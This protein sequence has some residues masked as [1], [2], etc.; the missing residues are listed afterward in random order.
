MGRESPSP[1]GV[2]VQ[3]RSNRRA[4]GPASQPFS[5]PHVCLF[6]CQLGALRAW[7]R[8]CRV[9]SPARL[10]CGRCDAIH[11]WPLA[12][13]YYNRGSVTLRS[14]AINCPLPGQPEG[15]ESGFGLET[16]D[17]INRGGL[18]EW[19]SVYGVLRKL[20][21]LAGES[22]RQKC[23]DL[24]LWSLLCNRAGQTS[25]PRLTCPQN[26]STFPT[27]TLTVYKV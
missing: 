20:H 19:M 15:E 2:S 27:K 12:A 24:G 1:S 16:G 5:P 23:V 10:F 4:L 3:G 26:G 13:V 7:R 22:A 25:I 14:C 17:L 6:L 11:R 8:R 21:N 9:T 18:G